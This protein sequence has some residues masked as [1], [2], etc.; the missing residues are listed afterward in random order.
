MQCNTFYF[1]FFKG[2]GRY[3]RYDGIRNGQGGRSSADEVLRGQEVWF[4]RELCGI[5]FAA[6]Y[7]GYSYEVSYY[8]LSKNQGGFLKFD[9]AQLI[10]KCA[11]SL[12][13]KRN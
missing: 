9:A 2:I 12:I 8:V 4:A 1:H 3:C 11:T 5:S 7:I 13:G 10:N 6:N